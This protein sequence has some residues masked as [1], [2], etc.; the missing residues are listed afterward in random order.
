MG[1]LLL[2]DRGCDPFGLGSLETAV[3]GGDAYPVMKPEQ[4]QGMSSGCEG[5]REENCAKQ[6]LLVDC[7]RTGGNVEKI[8]K[9]TIFK[10]LLSRCFFT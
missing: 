8:I 3:E 6:F 7:K 1:Q 9:Q 10:I 2:L 4:G 5:S